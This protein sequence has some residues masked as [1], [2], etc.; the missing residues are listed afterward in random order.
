[1]NPYW[2][3]RSEKW[4]GNVGLG[5][6]MA[7]TFFFLVMNNWYTISDKW[8]ESNPHWGLFLL[9]GLVAIVGGQVI[10][11]AVFTWAQK[12]VENYDARQ[13]KAKWI[14]RRRDRE[15]R[16]VLHRRSSKPHQK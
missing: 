8:D 14:D 9:H 6:V 16:E 11:V 12:R 1:M 10:G 13:L 3:R 5:M 4:F 2:L 7:F 15:M